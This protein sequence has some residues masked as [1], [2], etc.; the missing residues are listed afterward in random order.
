MVRITSMEFPVMSRA[1]GKRARVPPVHWHRH[2]SHGTHVRGLV[3]GAPLQAAR[4]LRGSRVRFRET[5]GRQPSS[6]RSRDDASERFGLWSRR[7][8]VAA[9]GSRRAATGVRND[10]GARPKTVEDHDRRSCHPRPLTW[11]LSRVFPVLNTTQFHAGRP[12]QISHG[13]SQGF[14][15][16]HLHPTDWQVKASPA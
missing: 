9:P 16:P 8:R 5:A 2:R 12:V 4:R 3:P 6:S 10:R 14:K 1:S 15:S 11:R 7:S 13:G